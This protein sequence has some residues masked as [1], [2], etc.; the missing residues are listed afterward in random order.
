MTEIFD[1]NPFSIDP[2]NKHLHDVWMGNQY[3]MKFTK[4]VNICRVTIMCQALN[5]LLMV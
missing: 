5:F 4:L 1:T 2:W 3:Q